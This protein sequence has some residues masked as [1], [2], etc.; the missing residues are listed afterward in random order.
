MGKKN[1]SD[2]LEPLDRTNE[3]DDAAPSEATGE[4]RPGIPD[5]L[6]LLPLRE[7]VIFPVLVTPL[8]VGREN[9]IKL[10]NDAIN[11]GDRLIGVTCLKDPTIE[12][13]TLDDV[14][15][16]GTVVAI[17]TMAQVPEG[18]RLIVQGIQRFEIVEA[19]KTT[20]YLRV[21]I[22]P[23]EEPAIPESE[24]MEIEA[25]KR[26]IGS[27]FVRIVQLSPDL[28]D[29]MQSLPNNVTDPSILTDL[30][31]QQMPRLTFQER[32]EILET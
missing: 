14:Y 1:L 12:N 28:P 4:G 2:I 11:A 8:G 29:E 21:K 32:Q 6:N 10:V 3:N 17:R 26:N 22:R 16:I 30:I 19:V 25:L 24:R 5:E 18:I 20:P 13:P 23:I 27:Q 7:V 31:A 9:S 15:K